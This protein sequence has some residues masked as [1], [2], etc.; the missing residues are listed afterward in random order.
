MA[1]QGKRIP[2]A[3]VAV[4]VFILL[5]FVSFGAPVIG[6]MLVTG[7]SDQVDRFMEGTCVL[8]VPFVLLTLLALMWAWF[9]EKRS[10]ATLG[11]VR[12]GALFSYAKGFGLGLVFMGVVVGTMAVIGGVAVQTDGTQPG[13]YTALGPVLIMLVIYIVQGGSEEMVIRGWFMQVLGARYRP[14]IAVL[15]SSVLFCALHGTPRPV[16]ILN[17]FLF[18]LFLSAYYLRAGSIWGICGWHS[19]WNWTMGNVFGLAVSGHEPAHGVLFDLRATGHP[20]LSG[21]DY[22]PEGSLIATI[23]LLLGIA[24]VVMTYRTRGADREPLMNE[25]APGR[26]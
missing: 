1:R 21:G 2:N 15:A 24:V 26:R 13:G 17:L 20:L 9:F 14:W 11:L 7:D 25:N 3:L 19:A 12:A 5:M 6:I 10:P 23:V 22:G 18:A 16:A 4:G 8:V